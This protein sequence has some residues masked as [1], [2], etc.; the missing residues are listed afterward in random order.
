MKPVPSLT[1]KNNYK[2]SAI[3]LDFDG[4]L[5][6]SNEEKTRAF[7]DLFALYPPYEKEM[8]SFHLDNH[9][10]PR[11]AKFEYFVYTIMGR[12]DDADGVFEMAQRFSKLVMRRVLDCP[13][14]AGARAFLEEFSKRVP[15]YLSSVTPFDELKEIL[16]I[17][18]FASFFK[19]V[20]GDP[21][22]N[23]K[24]AIRIVL[25]S[26]QLLPADVVFI[27]DSASDYR[28]ATENGLEFIG[29]DSGLP[30]DDIEIGLY[31]DLNEIADNVRLRI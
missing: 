12:S 29:R 31:G 1:V 18:G 4:V 25:E 23:K 19:K 16:R 15:L 2:I 14:V 30:F 13:E 17:R 8:M 28:V 22:F 24:E 20:F 21:P 9:S 27:G 6:E 10:S 5:V 11:M 26:E 3:I 7:K